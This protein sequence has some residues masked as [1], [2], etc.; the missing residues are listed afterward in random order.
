ME[1]QLLLANSKQLS[2]DM[3]PDIDQIEQG[4]ADDDD[5]LVAGNV[6]MVE[7]AS[8]DSGDGLDSSKSSSL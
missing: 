4:D 3:I 6:D 5:L 1:N 2:S 7:F 8:I